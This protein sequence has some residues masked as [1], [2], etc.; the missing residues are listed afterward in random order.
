MP[1]P[2]PKAIIFDWDNTLVDTWP[3]IHNALITTQKAMGH[4][5]WTMEQ[6][7]MRV[8]KSM[9]DSFSEIFG[10]RWQQAGEMYQKEYRASRDLITVRALP[11]ARELLDEV[12]R[13]GLYCVVVSNKK[14]GNLRHEIELLGWQELFDN[15][16]GS[17]DAAKDK[18]FVEPVV[19]AFKKT[20]LK[21]GPDVWFIGDSEI[22]LECALNCGCTAI[23][24]GE[25][26]RTHADYSETHYQGFPY[27][28][29]VDSHAEIMELLRAS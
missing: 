15:V 7:Q 13:R 24:Y 3:I 22:D 11:Q 18:P 9:R 23:L 26:A 27:H 1:L 29:H 2:A 10:E 4:A 16:V 8:R 17:D 6:T 20:H 28:V 5:P 25:L 21:P 12:R 19:L 14:G